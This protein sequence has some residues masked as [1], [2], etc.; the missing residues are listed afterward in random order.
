MRARTLTGDDQPLW[1]ALR[2][3]ALEHFPNA[4]LTTLE[5]ARA[6]SAESEREMLEQG[7]FIGVFDGE[8][9]VGMGGCRVL[10]MRACTHRAEIG[11]FFVTRSRQGRGVS[12]VLMNAIRDHAASKGAWQL[13]LFVAEDNPRAKRF[14]ERHGFTVCGSLPNAALVNGI[15]TSDLFMVADLR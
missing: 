15:M 14:Y 11:A 10:Q 9:L 6:R 8:D 7:T 2:L 13:E 4:F 12:D 5:E 3:E 1:R